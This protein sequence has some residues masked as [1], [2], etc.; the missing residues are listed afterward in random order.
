M[1]INTQGIQEAIVV[2]FSK[3]KKPHSAFFISWLD[4]EVCTLYILF[5][6]YNLKVS[7]IKKNIEPKTFYTYSVTS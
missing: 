3:D 5:Y 7:I 6:S 2:H 1:P 4:V